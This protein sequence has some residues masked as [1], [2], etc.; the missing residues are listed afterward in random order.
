M[1]LIVSQS[2]PE[3]QTH[4]AFGQI[5]NLQ[6]MRGKK[7][8]LAFERNAGCPVCN[9]RINQL[10]N[11][12]QLIQENAEV[13]LVYESSPEKM[14]EY[15]STGSY[16]FHFITDPDNHIYKLYAV[17]KSWLKVLTSLF[18]GIISKVNSG[19]KLFSKP[20]SQDGHAHT[21]PAE[22]IID[23][24]GKISVA[25]YGRFVG[26]HLTVPFLLRSLAQPV[27]V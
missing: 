10:L 6:Q 9:L 25:H 27:A 12:S 20:I 14:I 4:D 24:Y 23:E 16:P 2:A 1:K 3:F 19:Q 7:V 21:I 8:Y 11:H 13:L 18:N 5:I 26:D 17:E 15:L 22:F